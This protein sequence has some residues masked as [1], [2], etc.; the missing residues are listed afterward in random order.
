MSAADFKRDLIT[1]AGINA[2]TRSMTNT[3][4]IVMIGNGSYIKDLTAASI[5]TDEITATTFIGDGSQLTGISQGVIPDVLFRDI[6]GNVVGGTIDTQGNSIAAGDIIAGSATIGGTMMSNTEINA[7]GKAITSGA[8]ISTGGITTNNGA[9]NAGSGAIN[10]TGSITAGG[11][12]IG[13]TTMSNTAINASGRTITATSFVGDGS[14]LTGISQGVI[15]DVLIRDIRGNVVGGTIDTQGN[16]ITAGTITAGSVNVGSGA[17]TCGAITGTSMTVGSATIGGATMSATEINASGKTVTATSFVGGLT[18]NNGAVNAGTGAIT[19][20][21][22]ITAGSATIGGTTMT[23]TAIN[24]SGKT[25]TATSFVGG[26]TTNNGA[27]NA[28]TGAITGGAITGGAITGGAITGTS[29]NAGAGVITAGSATIGGTTM[30]ATEINASGKTVTAA[31]FVG[32]GSRLTGL[33]VGNYIAFSFSRTVQ[34]NIDATMAGTPVQFETAKF[35]GGVGAWENSSTYVVPVTGMYS[36]AWNLSGATSF[37][38]TVVLYVNS[39]ATPFQGQTRTGAYDGVNMMSG[40]IMAFAGDR[41]SLQYTA[42]SGPMSVPRST[43]RPLFN[44]SGFLM[45]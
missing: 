31:S 43:T 14:K 18:T 12:T 26:L 39:D 33:S 28:G 3:G 2:M 25:V 23:G 45:C 32:D 27:V 10:T 19:T 29:V 15:P 42:I 41:I 34:T 9:V 20:T 8:I 1:F 22:A 6:C 37:T 11:A 36:V 44:F 40:Q 5:T 21:G 7:A 13:G 38:A 16:T 30:S 17:I 4:N 24:A 35:Q